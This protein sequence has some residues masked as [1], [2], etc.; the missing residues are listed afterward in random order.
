[1]T[2]SRLPM[3]TAVATVHLL[4]QSHHQCTPGTFLLLNVPRSTSKPAQVSSSHHFKI[5]A[6]NHL[7]KTSSVQFSVSTNMPPWLLFEYLKSAL[8][9]CQIPQVLYPH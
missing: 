7:Q 1:V 9:L 2:L 4:S 5:G 8:K 3:I 6:E